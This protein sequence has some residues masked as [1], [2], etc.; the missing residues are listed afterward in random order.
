MSRTCARSIVR[1]T[2]GRR[3]TPCCRA[4]AASG[5]GSNAASCRVIAMRAVAERAG[6]DDQILRRE[7]HAIVGIVRGVRVQFG[8]DHGVTTR[9]RSRARSSFHAGSV[10]GA[11]P[12]A[13]CRIRVSI[14]WPVSG[15]IHE[16]AHVP[17]G[18]VTCNVLDAVAAGT[19][20]RGPVDPK[21][22][23]IVASSRENHGIPQIDASEVV[24]AQTPA[25][26]AAVGADAP[27]PGRNDLAHAVG[28]RPFEPHHA[29]A[30]VVE[31]LGG[32][33][34]CT[35]GVPL[36]RRPCPSSCRGRS[37]PRAAR[38]RR[39]SGARRRST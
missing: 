6:A 35:P 18:S 14:V 8:A 29:G 7:R 37:S 27:R 11:T 1:S 33:R 2:P 31:V 39:R 38:G 15:S 34:L 28:P 16:P 10:N 21:S 4:N 20:R 13:C 26:L 25:P 3:R 36:D 5:A 12:P 23:S 19:S 32:D 30:A 22:W 17:G 24:G 9:R